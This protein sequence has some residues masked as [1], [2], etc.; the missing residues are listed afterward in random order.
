MRIAYHLGAHC[1]DD[2]RLLRTLIA[3]RALLADEGVV[4][5][6]PGGFVMMI[7]V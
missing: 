3:N 7:V 2:E 1:T 4:V 5:P 6:D